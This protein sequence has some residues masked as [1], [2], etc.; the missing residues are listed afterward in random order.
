MLL[1]VSLDYCSAVFQ[2]I[3]AEEPGSYVIYWKEKPA[4]L[5]SVT[6][7]LPEDFQT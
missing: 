4:Q 6:W 7:L 5:E 2:N 3:S 1:D